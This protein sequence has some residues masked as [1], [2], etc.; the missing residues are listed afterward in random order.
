MVLYHPF[1]SESW[2]SAMHRQFNLFDWFPYI[3][4]HIGVN[5]LELT[6]R[7]IWLACNGPPWHSIISRRNSCLS[8]LLSFSL[9]HPHVRSS[10]DVSGETAKVP[11]KPNSKMVAEWTELFFRFGEGEFLGR[12]L[13]CKNIRVTWDQCLS[14]QIVYPWT[15]LFHCHVDTIKPD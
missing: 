4:A 15:Y 2:V 10:L 14:T 11:V 5:C 13:H 12:S 1:N 8:I 7:C 9:T 6:E 3:K